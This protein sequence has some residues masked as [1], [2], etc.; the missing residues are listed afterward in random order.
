MLTENPNQVSI[1][2]YA[3]ITNTDMRKKLKKISSTLPRI[4]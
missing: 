4:K 1:V 3:L 2:I